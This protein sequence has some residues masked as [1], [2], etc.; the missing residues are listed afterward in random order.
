MDLEEYR[1]L[2][3]GNTHV[4]PH[5]LTNIHGEIMAPDKAF[6]YWRTEIGKVSNFSYWYSGSLYQVGKA[7]GWEREYMF[8]ASDR[9]RARF[10][11]AEAWRMS[12]IQFVQEWGYVQL[13]DGHRRTRLEATGRWAQEFRSKFLRY[14]NHITNW[15]ADKVIRRIQARANNQIINAMIQGSCATLIKRSLLSSRLDCKSRGWGPRE[16]RFMFPVHDEGVF[17]VHREIVP[18]FIQ[19]T[20]AIM[21]N[22]PEII[23][24]LKMDC[25]PSIGLTF[26]P[27][28]KK[29]ARLGQIE[30]REIPDIGL[31]PTNDV[32]KE[33]PFAQWGE[34]VDWL[35]AEQRRA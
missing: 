31:V 34:A 11:V 35:F 27:W 6:K 4:S 19:A 20:S 32:G 5:L 28:D 3:T 26:E 1:S 18:E 33:L 22:H 25:S 2:K 7:L 12:T 29:R 15:F 8:E 30:L 24:N 23:S 17:S 14:D 9:Y 21:C 16:A 10:S 13:P